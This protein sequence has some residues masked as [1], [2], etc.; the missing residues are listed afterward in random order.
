MPDFHQAGDAAV[1]IEQVTSLFAG[2]DPGTRQLLLDAAQRDLAEWTDLL[3]AAWDS[4]DADGQHRA[5]HSLKGLCGNFGAA[6]LLALCEADLA[7]PGMAKR[8]QASR[9]TTTQALEQLIAK[10]DQ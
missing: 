1:D 9:I 6:G 4:G 10:L 3:V 5:R 7:Q 8:L 2:L